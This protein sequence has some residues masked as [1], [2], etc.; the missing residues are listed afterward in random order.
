VAPLVRGWRRDSRGGVKIWRQR[1]PGGE[2]VA[3]CAGAGA[4]AATRA[5]GEIQRDG[6]VDL[7]ISTG[8]AGALREEYAA[9]LAYP[10]RGIVDA[11]TG[12]RFDTAAPSGDCWLVTATRFADREE[13]LRL[14]AAYGAGLVDMEAAAVARLAGRRGIPFCCVKGVSDGVADRLPDFSRF[15]SAGGRLHWS[16]LVLFAVLRPRH[17]PALLRVRKNCGRAAHGLR[18]SLLELLNGPRPAGRREGGPDGKCD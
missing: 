1:R 15:I 3:A 17:W 14:A 7:V 16:G 8:W 6:T 2:W 13:K 11:R 5:L 4:E 18:D 9:G 12:E 10:V